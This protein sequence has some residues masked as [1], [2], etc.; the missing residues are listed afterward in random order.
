M[1]IPLIRTFLLAPAN[2]LDL[3]V[4]FPRFKAD[5]SVIDLEDGTPA[6]DKVCARASLNHAVGA[7]RDGGYQGILAVRVNEPLS[8]L[9]LDDL[10][11]AFEAGADAVVI[12]KVEDAA[13]LW[14][15]SHHISR[16][17]NAHPR[18][19]RRFIISGV[20]SARGVRAVDAACSHALGV[21]A[22]YF[23]AED[24]ATSVGGRR[25]L[26]GDEVHFA[27]SAV[28]MA[29]K[30]AGIQAID[31]AFVDIRDDAAY[32]ADAVR[33]RD[34]G[35]DGKTCLTPGQI[36][37]ASSVFAPS[38]EELDWAKRLVVAHESALARNVGV[39]EFEGKMIDAPLLKR[40]RAILADR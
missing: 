19:T 13:Q 2:R 10:H 3:L 25:T 28:V 18:R 33:G 15:A 40:A 31:Q 27:R 22:V 38:E 32:T 20:E 12:P 23:G 34:L 39:I 17:A 8:P 24:Y 11:A 37:L 7:V 30:A 4:K 29:A 26:V 6:A 1:T 16:L 14:A 36:K 5:C 9:F 21:R 35:Y